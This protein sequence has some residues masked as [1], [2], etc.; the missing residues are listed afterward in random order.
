[1]K[2]KK[3]YR[4]DN[5]LF[6][7]E[8]SKQDGV[9]SLDGGIFYKVISEG[10]GLGG[11][12]PMSVVTVHYRGSLVSGHVFDDSWTRSCPDAFRVNTLI[13]GFQTALCNMRIGDRWTVYIPWQKGYG[14]RSEGDIPGF[15]TLIF[16]IELIHVT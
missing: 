16:E 13:D 8:I 6:L 4:Q 11:I 14:K 1:M 9:K 12:T 15:S 10:K 7:K 5:E 3:E 2:N